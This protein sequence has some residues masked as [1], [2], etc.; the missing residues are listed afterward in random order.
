[1]TDDNFIKSNLEKLLGVKLVTE[2]LEGNSEGEQ[3][4]FCNLID[5]LE[6]LID[7]ERAML[8]EHGVDTSTLVNPYW[9]AIE[10]LIDF[11]S[12]PEIAD[13]VWWYL[14]S[15]KGSK[16]EILKWV[17]EDGDGESYTFKDSSELY[18]Y[19]YTSE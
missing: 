17:D 11:T 2:K 8:R 19:I 5:C 14:H 10:D 1:M 15:R 9:D 4:G 16:G 12:E 3:K 7:S 13:V 18:A 6:K